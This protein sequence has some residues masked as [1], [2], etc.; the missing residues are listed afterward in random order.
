MRNCNLWTRL[1]VSYAALFDPGLSGFIGI[2]PDSIAG[3]L[4]FKCVSTL[5]VV[6]MMVSA[7]KPVY[8][9][10]GYHTRS[11]ASRR[12]EPVAGEPRPREV[13][14]AAAGQRVAAR[15]PSPFDGRRLGAVPPP[16]P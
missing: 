8:V 15:D 3:L 1:R 14:G 2:L 11:F 10:R 7:L 16:A 4:R 6:L 12:E 5:I 9:G 13:V